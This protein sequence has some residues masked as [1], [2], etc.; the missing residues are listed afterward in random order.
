M[1]VFEGAEVLS[2]NSASII[3]WQRGNVFITAGSVC[4]ILLYSCE[5]QCGHV[6]STPDFSSNII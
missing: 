2:L 1:Q 6:Y 4:Y 3:V 5:L